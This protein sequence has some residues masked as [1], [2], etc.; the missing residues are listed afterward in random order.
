VNF[1]IAQFKPH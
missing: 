1:I